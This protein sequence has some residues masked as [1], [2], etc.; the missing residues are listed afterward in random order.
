MIW[1]G[2]SQFKR[3]PQIEAC[4]YA[5]Q[6]SNDRRS[7]GNVI[8]VLLLSEGDRET[9]IRSGPGVPLFSDSAIRI[10]DRS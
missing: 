3:T 1:N 6:R 5:N 10:P 8:R 9:G 2:P 4:P 7:Y